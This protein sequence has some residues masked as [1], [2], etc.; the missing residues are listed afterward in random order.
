MGEG[1]DISDCSMIMMLRKTA[2][3][4]LFIQMS[5]RCMRY[6]KGKTAYIYDFCG[7]V[8]EHGLPDD[9]RSWSLDSKM[10]MSRNESA[11]PDIL[12]RQCKSCLRV[13][14][15][16]SRICPYCGTNN[17]LTRKEIEQ[18][19]KRQNWNGLKKLNASKKRRIERS[20]AVARTRYERTGR[21]MGYAPGLG[22]SKVE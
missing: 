4:N 12:V 22:V 1:L 19:Q 13:Y 5:M 21:K 8:F 9:K 7:N 10:K 18:G 3:L 15:G 2:S 6:Q 14:S 20:W 11:E 16:T 17:G